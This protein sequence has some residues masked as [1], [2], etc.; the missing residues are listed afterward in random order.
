M[1]K[2]PV[3]LLVFAAIITS[4][5]AV[6]VK[7]TGS[8][9]YFL[10][11]HSPEKCDREAKKICGNKRVEVVTKSETH[12]WSSFIPLL[13]PWGKRPVTRQSISCQDAGASR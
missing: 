3:S 7:K 4:C 11:C 2:N 1:T 8:S 13:G 5:A 12:E 6:Q 10:K 9:T